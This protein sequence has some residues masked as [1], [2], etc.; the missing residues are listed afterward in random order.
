MGNESVREAGSAPATATVSRDR[1]LEVKQFLEALGRSVTMGDGRAAVRFWEVPALVIGERAVRTVTTNA[2]VE[3][4]F[5]TV[6]HQ[7]YAR[8]IIDTRPEVLSLEWI[9]DRIVVVRVRWPYL[10]ASGDERGSETMTYTLRRD[11]TG[12]LRLRAAILHNE[13]PNH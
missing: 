6:K 10:D 7:Y 5:A 1:D 4:H 13:T 12:T 9:T 2:E 8:G 3:E 11:D